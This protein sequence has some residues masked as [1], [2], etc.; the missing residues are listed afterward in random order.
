MSNKERLCSLAHIRSHLG[1]AKQLGFYLNM[2]HQKGSDTLSRIGA[3]D[4]EMVYV[5]IRLNVCVPH[6]FFLMLDD[7]RLKSSHMASPQLG[8]DI[9]WCPCID[10]L[11]GV[12]L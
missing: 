2:L 4:E 3:G 1:N 9:C 6:N 8:V 11:W 5:T 12:V 7:K 10:L